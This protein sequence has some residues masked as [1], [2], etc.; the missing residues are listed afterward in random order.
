[1]AGNMNRCIL[2]RHQPHPTSNQRVLDR[3][4]RPLIARY[5]P[6]GENHRVAFTESYMTVTIFSD[7]T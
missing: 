4:N 1:M 5:D 7:S 2:V 6:T 3:T